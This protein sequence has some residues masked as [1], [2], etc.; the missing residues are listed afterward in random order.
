MFEIIP[1]ID[2]IEGRCVRLSE[3]DFANKTVYRDDPLAVAREF[4]SAGLRRLHMVDLD[5]ARTGRV[6]NLEV[7]ERI[8][9][10]TGLVIDFGGGI[11]TADDLKN[12]YDAGARMANIGSLAVKE[13]EK[14][15][16]FVERFG[17]ERVLL[18]A[19]VRGEKL[20]ID[21]WQTATGI[22]IVPF[23]R[24][25]LEKGVAQAFVT[26]IS[27]DGRLAGS[28]DELYAKILDE[29]PGLR[30]I[31]SGGVGNLEDVVRLERIGCAGVIIGKAI[32]EGRVKLEELMNLYPQMN[33]D[34]HG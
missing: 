9:A 32:Y 19:D 31:A 23:L 27:R 21:G 13:P 15:L 20:A 25:Y 12:V 29:V 14:F 6:V 3:G 2:L 1:A 28:S 22:E 7:L 30:L 34:G 16:S 4:E 33:T 8:A 10:G 26:D 18:G 5:G 24:D 17:G 11:K